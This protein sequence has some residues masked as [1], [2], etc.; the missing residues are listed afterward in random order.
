MVHHKLIDMGTII[1]SK[2]ESDNLHIT[3]PTRLNGIMRIVDAIQTLTKRMELHQKKFDGLF[4]KI[5]ELRMNVT[6]VHEAVSTPTKPPTAS[7][8]VPI[9]QRIVSGKVVSSKVTLS[10]YDSAMEFY[11][12]I[13]SGSK[14]MPLM[15][16]QNRATG[17][18]IVRWF[19]AMCTDEENE[20]LLKSD[21]SLQLK[22]NDIG[23]T[24]SK[25]IRAY[26]RQIFEA[27]NVTVPKSLLKKPKGRG[28]HNLLK[29]TA[30]ANRLRDIK[31]LELDPPIV[32]HDS[33][34]TWRTHYEKQQKQ[35]D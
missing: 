1:R 10:N 33:F 21:P 14:G 7:K 4:E 16:K 26:L 6:D 31:K 15:N 29:P 3:G 9:T 20:I 11:L 27:G 32:T 2:F 5:K 22:Q 34:Q 24:L 13:K 25:L 35:Q 12:S 30:I 19:N 28:K 8:S 23:L 18:L 17:R